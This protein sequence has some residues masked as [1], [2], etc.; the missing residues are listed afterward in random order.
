[1]TDMLQRQ[2][3]LRDTWFPLQ[4]G[5]SVIIALKTYIL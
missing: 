4:D 2:R 1:M 3:L 5:A